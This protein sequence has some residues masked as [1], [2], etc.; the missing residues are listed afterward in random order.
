LPDIH[1]LALDCG[2]DCGI[3]CGVDCIVAAS[4]GIFSPKSV[5]A[6]AMGT[7]ILL[8]SNRLFDERLFI[9]VIL[10]A[11]VCRVSDVMIMYRM[12]EM[13]DIVWDI[14]WA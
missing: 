13:M 6:T 9:G 2:I 10:Y 14:V 7:L 1:R 12:V 3:D 8:N 11:K 5:V 4:V